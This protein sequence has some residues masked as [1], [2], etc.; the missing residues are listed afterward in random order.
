MEV[1]MLFIC[2]Q[3]G[4]LEVWKLRFLFINENDVFFQ[5][6]SYNSV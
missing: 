2:F 4:N 1:L 6:L 3:K 5:G